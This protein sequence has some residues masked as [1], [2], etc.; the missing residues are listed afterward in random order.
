MGSDWALFMDD[1]K[2]PIEK[3]LSVMLMIRVLNFMV[4]SVYDSSVCRPDE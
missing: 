4:I 1:A 3:M 2:A